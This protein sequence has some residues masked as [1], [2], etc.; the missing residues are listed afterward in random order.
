MVVRL[1]DIPFTIFLVKISSHLNFLN[2]CLVFTQNH[3]TIYEI[4]DYFRRSD[5]GRNGF[6]QL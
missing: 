5:F 3:S 2:Y 1:K 4:K 6:V